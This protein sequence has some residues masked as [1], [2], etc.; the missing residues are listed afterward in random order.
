MKKRTHVALFAGL[1]GFVA[2][3]HRAG[4]ETI[5]ANDV[6][7]SCV[8]TLRATYPGLNVSDQDVTQIDPARDL[9]E[10]GPIDLL[11][12]GFPCQSFSGAGECKGFEDER[13]KLFFEIPRICKQLKVPPKVIL[14]ENVA[15]L[16]LFDN[17][18]RLATVLH[19]L[20]SAGYWVS[21]NHAMLINSKKLCGAPQNRERLFI[22]AYHSRHFKKNYFD[23]DF[24]IECPEQDIWS[25]IERNEVKDENYYLPED[26]KYF[27]LIKALSDEEGRDRVYQIRRVEVRACPENTCPTLT[28]NMGG[29]GHNV[30]FVLDD[31]GIRKLT[32]QECLALQGFKLDEV[33]FPD[34]IANNQKYAMIGNAI[35]VDV[36]AAI[37]ERI[38]YAKEKVSSDD[39]MVLS[40]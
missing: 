29:G 10:L 19:N 16:K 40:A 25:V 24:Q 22:V 4:F 5:F 39:R 32:E 7:P 36:A 18:S 38:D 31:Q 33:T 12:A 15:H 11:T 27:R 35:H 1:G 20:R 37:I 13:G 6:E 26:N 23:F 3:S 28:A 14:L 17:G 34:N 30:P 9:D 8:K 21:S 2:A